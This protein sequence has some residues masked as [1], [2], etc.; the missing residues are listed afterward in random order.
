[1]VRSTDLPQKFELNIS[2]HI[3][4]LFLT[5][6]DF[7]SQTMNRLM[8][9]I[10]ECSTLRKIDL[11]LTNLEDVSSLTLSNKTSLTHLH[12]RW[13]HMSQEL[14]WS[15]CHQ[16]TDLTQLEYLNLSYNDL[17]HIDTIHLS[18]KPNLS[19]LNCRKTQMSV[20]LCKNVIGQ[21]RHIS[22]LSY[23]DLSGNTLTGCLT[24]FLPDP[25]PGI[26]ELKEIHLSGTALDKEDLQH[27]T[28]LIQT[29]KLPGLETL[30]LE[31]N[32]FRGIE[33]DVE[34]LIEACVSHHQRGLNL[35]MLG[36]DLSDAFREKWK[37][38]C[39]GTNIG[40]DFDSESE[41]SDGDSHTESEVSDGDEY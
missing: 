31:H 23:L 5:G 4:S 32:R 7:P 33:T 41:V 28:H 37:Q 12:L 22:R 39:A 40:L 10:N 18:N 6:C 14:S 15:V 24:N 3:Q 36:N 13:T 11:Y 21:L 26:P 38:R 35:V 2:K 19:H 8:E 34:H 16:L 17:S 25:H 20:T 9:Q 1:M 27:L 29:H 30:D